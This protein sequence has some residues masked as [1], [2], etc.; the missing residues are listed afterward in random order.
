ML[1]M[2]INPFAPKTIMRQLPLTRLRMGK[3]LWQRQ[4]AYLHSYP[5]CSRTIPRTSPLY[6]RNCRVGEWFENPWDDS[7]NQ[8]GTVENRDGVNVGF[9]HLQ[10][11]ST[12][13]AMATILL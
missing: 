5:H 12:M 9:W 3:H 8:S 4:I 1:K 11:P 2:W 7:E 6:G 10:L 13:A